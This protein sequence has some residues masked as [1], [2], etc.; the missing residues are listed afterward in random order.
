MVDL[1]VESFPAPIC[2]NQTDSEEEKKEKLL[3]LYMF[4]NK[5]MHPKG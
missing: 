4:T 1:D 3:Y 2:L 5:I